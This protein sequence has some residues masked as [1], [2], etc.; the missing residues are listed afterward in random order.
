MSEV[1]QKDRMKEYL[2]LLIGCILYCASLLFVNRISVIPGSMLGIAVVSNAVLGTP[3]GL[4]NLLLN[5]PVMVFVT[6]RY[7][8]K[9]LIYTILIMV[10]TSLLIDLWEPFFPDPGIRNVYLISVIGG[11][12]MGLGAGLLIRAGGTMAGTTALTLLIREKFPDIHYGTILFGMDACIMLLGAILL[13]DW[14]AVIYSTIYG[15]LV[16]KMM[17]VVIDFGKGRTDKVR[18]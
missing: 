17:D 7:G 13:K 12:V 4:V 14:K 3:I 2:M 10:G 1:L 18:A 8:R 9:I 16:S 5:I 6:R 15:L 11:I